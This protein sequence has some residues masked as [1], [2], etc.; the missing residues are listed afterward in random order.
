ML[1]RQHPGPVAVVRQIFLAK[2][3]LHCNYLTF[4]RH[5]NNIMQ[6][7]IS[8]LGINGYINLKT[9]YH[10]STFKILGVVVHS[11][12]RWI[13]SW[14]YFSLMIYLSFRRKTD[15]GV[16]SVVKFCEVARK[17]YKVT[18]ADSCLCLSPKYPEEIGRKI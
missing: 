17:S 11:W 6:N 13:Q 2:S 8:Q 16:S 14:S 5:D 1:T 7:N 12:H 15:G 3:S 4:A 10:G 9:A 18:T